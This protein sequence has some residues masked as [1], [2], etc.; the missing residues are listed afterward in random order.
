MTL[1][2]GGR[3][4]KWYIFSKNKP[5]SP[6]C[7]L[8]PPARTKH[9]GLKLSGYSFDPAASKS[10]TPKEIADDLAGLGITITDDTV[11]KYLKEAAKSV[12]PAI[13]RKS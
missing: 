2:S 12:L 10:A 8:S 4:S 7:A 3:L 11:R 6:S 5:I 1:G 9:T 13:P